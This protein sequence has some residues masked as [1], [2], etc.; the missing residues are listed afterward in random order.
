MTDSY[1]RFLVD[2]DAWANRRLLEFFDSSPELLAASAP[3]V[4]GT[5]GETLNHLLDAEL[6]YVERLGGNPRSE[7]SSGLDLPALKALA[8]K[9]AWDATELLRALPEAETLFQRSSGKVNAATVLG[10]MIVHGVEHRTHV[11]TILG[12]LGLEPPDLAAWQ[13]G[14]VFE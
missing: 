6:Y 3:G 1:L 7:E 12:S 14:P 11:G 9:L 13:F 8:A 2:Y 5:A 10:Q 4:F